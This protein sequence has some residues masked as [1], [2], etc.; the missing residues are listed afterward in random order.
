M[1]ESLKSFVDKEV[2]TDLEINQGNKILL[3]IN[4]CLSG[5]QYSFGTLLDEQLINIVPI[6]VY[7]MLVQLHPQFNISIKQNN[8]FI[9][10]KASG[11]ILETNLTYPYLRLLLKFDCA[12]FLNVISTCIDAPVFVIPEQYDGLKKNGSFSLNF[13]KKN[14]YIAFIIIKLVFLIFK[15]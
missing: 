11:H 7:K 10:E 12:Q 9:E 8:D 3:Y 2:Y 13:K 14:F 4:C 15:K 1:F 6:S 5:R